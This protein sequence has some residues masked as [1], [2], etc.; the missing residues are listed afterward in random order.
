MPTLRIG[1]RRSA[2]ALAQAK[3]VAAGLRALGAE[4]ELVAIL[5]SGDRG[6][7]ASGSPAGRKGLF[8]AEIVRALQVGDVDLA[9]HSAKDLPSE[10]PDGVIVAAIPERANPFDVLVTREEAL[11]DDGVVGTSSL[12]RQAQL[13]RVRPALRMRDVRG[14]VDTRLRALGAGELEGLLLAAA[15]L[16]RLAI[17][18]PHVVP[19]PVEEMVPAPGQGAL[20]VQT[21]DDPGSAAVDM[22]KQLDHGPSR[23]GFEDER[24]VVR[25]L[26]GG[27]ALPLGAYAE[28]VSDGFRLLAVV[29]RPDG[30]DLVRAEAE[31]RTPEV[32]AAEVADALLAGGAAGILE[33]VRVA[34]DG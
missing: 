33:D 17:A 3:E 30:S 4:T 16:G 13:R 1:T 8:V 21:R 9:V 2:L 29:I 5:T 6:A 23:R 18:P 19:M 10:D 12:R 11:A 15:G 26:G 22:V 24:E 32:A 14:N 34:A 31:G 28:A 25:R 27:C 20:A 7:G